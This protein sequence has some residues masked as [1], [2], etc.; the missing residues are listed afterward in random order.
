MTIKQ[1]SP[2]S[3]AEIVISLE[4]ALL[5]NN[6]P[7]HNFWANITQRTHIQLYPEGLPSLSETDFFSFA[8]FHRRSHLKILTINQSDQ[9]VFYFFYFD[10]IWRTDLKHESWLWLYIM[11]KPSFIYL[12]IFYKSCN[13]ATDGTN[14]AKVARKLLA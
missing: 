8:S 1:M 9:H 6:P 4:S 11:P 7:D 14:N 10:V 13:W 2:D 12:F 3:E 5:L